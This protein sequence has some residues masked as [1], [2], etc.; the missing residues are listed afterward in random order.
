[1]ADIQISVPAGESKRLLTEG[2]YCDRDIV[3]TAESAGDWKLVADVTIEEEVST[4][5]IN[6]DQDGAPFSYTEMYFIFTQITNDTAGE[7]WVN[8]SK[9]MLTPVKN[10]TNNIYGFLR[11]IN[12]KTLV[13]VRG[14][15][16][17]FNNGY[18]AY[19][20]HSLQNYSEITKLRLALIRAQAGSTLQVY[21]R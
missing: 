12:D 18:G 17:G 9:M 2:K 15:N 20:Y 16:F 10:A 7:F 1:M 5:D 21:G 19:M 11:V 6:K 3:V 13:S 4:I 8:G 14:F